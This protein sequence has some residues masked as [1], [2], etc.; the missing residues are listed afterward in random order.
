MKPIGQLLLLGVLA[1]ASAWAATGFKYESDDNKGAK[2]RLQSV[3]RS[4]VLARQDVELK[5]GRE[6]VVGL[7]VDTESSVG[8]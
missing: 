6:T 3:A 5:S 2:L 7:L 8:L 1:A 4:T